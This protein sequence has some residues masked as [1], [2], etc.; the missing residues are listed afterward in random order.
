MVIDINLAHTM[1]VDDAFIFF[2][3]AKGLTQNQLYHIDYVSK[4]ID[5]LNIDAESELYDITALSFNAYSYVADK[6]II[7]PCG[8]SFGD[9]YGPKLVARYG[10][11]EL[12]LGQSPVAIPS[13]RT[14]AA[15]LLQLY[16]P[17]T[18]V[19]EYPSDSIIQAI[20]E[21]K[22]DAGVVIHEGQLIYED[23]KL[24]RLLDFGVWW[25]QRTGG[26]PVPL[27][28]FALHRRLADQLMP[29][30]NM[31]RE[32]ILYAL[33][34]RE[35]AI[36]YAQQTS[37]Y[38]DRRSVQT[39]IA[40]YVNQNSLDMGAKGRQSVELMLSMGNELGITPT[41]E[42]FNTIWR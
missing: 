40:M 28:C 12:R 38:L 23:Y 14:S 42:D 22:V 25:A 15:C 9:R 37:N 1:D 24:K 19:V 33:D 20:T 30:T 35:E 6:Y 36:A 29:I 4:S 10:F 5:E 3:L 2:A 7:L 34:H 17:G 13:A 27:G 16:R 41:I 39:Y 11:D 31:L 18:P 32:A 8:A 26:L 21:N